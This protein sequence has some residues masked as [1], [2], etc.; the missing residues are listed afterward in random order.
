M[1]IMTRFIRLCKADIHGVMDQFEDK[2]LLLKQYLRD[3]E[4]ELGEQKARLRLLTSA[5]ETDHLEHRKYAQEIAQTEDEIE[6]A[7]QKDKDDIARFLIKKIKPL[8]RLHDETGCKIE[9]SDAEISRLKESIAQQQR[10]LNE[11]QLRSQNYLRK[12]QSKNSAA[13][14]ADFLDNQNLGEPSDEEIESELFRRKEK[15][16]KEV[17]P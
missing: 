8:V 9:L 3:M 4:E 7:I 1:S 15:L 14:L 16:C 6:T 11:I 17:R 13:D 5:R 12:V 10:Q 2:E